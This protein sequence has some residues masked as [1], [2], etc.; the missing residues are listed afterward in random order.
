VKIYIKFLVA[1][2]YYVIDL[3]FNTVM[4]NKTM[5]CRY[6]LWGNIKFVSSQISD[7]IKNIKALQITY[8]HIYKTYIKH[9]EWIVIFT[10]LKGLFFFIFV[11]LASDPKVSALLRAD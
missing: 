6:K 9:S 3:I 7:K 11:L 8:I 2:G 4:F 1:L 10:K 5:A